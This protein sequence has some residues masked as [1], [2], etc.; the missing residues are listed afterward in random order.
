MA[1]ELIIFIEKS[2]LAVGLAS[3][4]TLIVFYMYYAITKAVLGYAIKMNSPKNPGWSAT[5]HRG[6]AV[7]TLSVIKICLFIS[8]VFDIMFLIYKKLREL[9]LMVKYVTF[10]HSYVGSNLTAF[11]YYNRL[12]KQ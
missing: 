2:Y 7:H 8:I 10:N 9:S 5:P 4:A 12:E 6:V 11:S 3:I 1:T